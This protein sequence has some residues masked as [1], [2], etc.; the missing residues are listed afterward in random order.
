MVQKEA[1]TVLEV[2][3]RGTSLGLE[4]QIKFLE[5]VTFSWA[6]DSEQSFQGQIQ[7]RGKKGIGSRREGCMGRL[8]VGEDTM[9]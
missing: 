1:W 6:M 5:A 4:V 3:N 8:E 9:N 2:W 7:G